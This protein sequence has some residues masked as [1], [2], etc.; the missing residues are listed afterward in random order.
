MRRG[1][2]VRVIAGLSVALAVGVSGGARAVDT[3][4][5]LDQI[6]AGSHRDPANSVRDKYRH[7]KEGL[8]FFGIQPGM[9]VVEV[10]PSGG[11]W[12]EVLAPLLKDDGRYYAAWFPTEWP[13]TP[14]YLKEREKD[15]DAKLAARPDLYGKVI[16][17]KLL[18]PEYVDIA[19]KGSADMVLTFRNVH[20]WAK[21]GNA[22]AMFKAFYDA[23]KPGGVLGVVDHRANPGTAFQRQ[24]DSGYLTEEYVIST[25]EKAGFK[26]AAKS[27]VNANPKDTKDYPGGVWTLPPTLREGDKDREKYLDIGESDR[28]TLK[29]V[30]P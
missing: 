25:A 30:K 18:A 3:A 12:T 9:T 22:D 5:Q 7:P 6:L 8:L 16:K 19:P 2:L 26:L 15:F 17:T 20:N 27:E 29:F 24:I 28:M 13:K 10:W 14:G 21:A 11:W 23:L 4:Q 1:T